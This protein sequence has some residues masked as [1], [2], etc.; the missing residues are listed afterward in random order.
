[1][2]RKG[3]L[4]LSATASAFVLTMV[5]GLVARSSQPEPTAAPAEWQAREAEYQ[6]LIGEA[7]RRLAEPAPTV[8]VDAPPTQPAFFEREDEDEHHSRSRKHEREHEDDDD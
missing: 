4:V 7:N 5:G 2:T 6:K 1:M 3:A 8:T